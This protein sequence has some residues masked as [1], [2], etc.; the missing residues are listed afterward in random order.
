MT[1]G[2]W[3]Y[4]TLVPRTA[5]PG[6]RNIYFYKIKKNLYK[7]EISGIYKNNQVTKA[8]NK[9]EEVVQK[10]YLPPFQR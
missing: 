1:K 8:L 2:F 4:P 7:F 6:S 10:D 5:T 9:Y 3:W